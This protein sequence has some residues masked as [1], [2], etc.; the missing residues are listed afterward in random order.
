RTSTWMVE[1]A[2]TGGGPGAFRGKLWTDDLTARGRS[3]VDLSVRRDE[4]EPF[5]LGEPDIDRIRSPQTR[6]NGHRLD[7]LRALR[8]DGHDGCVREEALDESIDLGRPEARPRQRRRDLDT[9]DRRYDDRVESLQEGR[10]KGDRR[11]MVR[12]VRPK[13]RHRYGGVEHI[14]H[15]RPRTRSST[16]AK[17]GS[18][19]WAASW[20]N[21]RTSSSVMAFARAFFGT[22]T[23]TGTIAAAGF[24]WRRITM[25]FFLCSAWSTSSDRWALAS[26]RDV[27]ITMTIMTRSAG[28]CHDHFAVP[29]RQGGQG[30]DVSLPSQFQD[31]DN[32]SS[33][34][35]RRSASTVRW[36]A[37][38]P[39]SAAYGPA[40]TA[41]P[42]MAAA[43]TARNCCTRGSLSPSGSTFAASSRFALHAAQS[44]SAHLASAMSRPTSAR[45][46]SVGGGACATGGG[47]C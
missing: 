3:L 33:R 42:A 31:Q 39:P 4:G 44:L 25:R 19:H 30:D 27:L 20:K 46:L 22:A 15:R 6:G 10:Q 26:A 17:F 32:S 21:A 2:S 11:A 37:H 18:P 1:G 7:S 24:P 29:E 36:T 41:C 43:I 35:T 47:G 45:S 12:L 38:H 9:E 23:S 13:R 16:A 14:L 40:S 34:G 28:A 5:L 8:A